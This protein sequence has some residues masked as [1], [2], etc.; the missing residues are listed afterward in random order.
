MYADLWLVVVWATYFG[1][2]IRTLARRNEPHI[3]VASWY[4]MAFILI[5]AV[6]YIF[7]NIAAPVSWGGSRSYILWSGV[8]D[9]TR[10]QGQSHADDTIE[11]DMKEKLVARH[12]R[13]HRKPARSSRVSET[14][15]DRARLAAQPCLPQAALEDEH[16]ARLTAWPVDDRECQS[17]RVL[18][19]AAADARDALAK[20]DT[21]L[22]PTMKR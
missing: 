19:L 6:L 5:V 4:Y 1:L 8:Q 17:A 11:P 3:Y 21:S 9:A 16:P 20:S 15:P 12:L 10:R 13:R 22:G 2:Y 14:K 7:N 18:S